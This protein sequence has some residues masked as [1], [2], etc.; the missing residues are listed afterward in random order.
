[1]EH[2]EEKVQIFS[3]YIVALWQGPI[4]IEIFYMYIYFNLTEYKKSEADLRIRGTNM[5]F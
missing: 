2:L 4:F 1:M 3:N 5:E